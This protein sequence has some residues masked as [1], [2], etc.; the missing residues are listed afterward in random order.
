[1]EISKTI[2]GNL[3]AYVKKAHDEPNKEFEFVL[4]SKQVDKYGFTRIM[5]HLYKN[6]AFNLEDVSSREQLDIRVVSD[7]EDMKNIRMSINDKN[8]IMDY[9]KTGNT[10]VNDLTMMRKYSSSDTRPI[11]LDDYYIRGNLK[12]EENIE[13]VSEKKEYFMKSNN[14]M[15]H[16]R[17]KK[18][19]SFAHN[20]QVCRIDLSIVRSSSKSAKNMVKSGVLYEPENYEVEI[21]Y[22]PNYSN[23]TKSKMDKEDII[24]KQMLQILH[25]LCKLNFGVEYLIPQTKKHTIIQ[26]YVSLVDSSIKQDA[27]ELIKKPGEYCLKYQ[28]VTLMK[29]NLLEPDVDVVSIRDKYCV[30]DK[31]D[32]ERYLLYIS[33]DGKTYLINNV[34]DIFYT[35]L[36]HNNAKKCIIDGELIKK[37]KLNLELNMFAAF[38]IYFIDGKDVRNL[39]LMGEKTTRLSKMQELLNGDMFIEDS[40]SK[41]KSKSQTTINKS[42]STLTIKVKTFE[43]SDDI[44]QSSAKILKRLPSLPYNTDGLIYT[45][46]NL[47]PGALYEN[48]KTMK[49]FGGSW[50]KVFK[51]KPPEDNSID[52]LVKL[53]KPINL[54]IAE[55]L[56]Q[57]CIYVKMYVAFRGS[58]DNSIEVGNIYD[59][60]S[61]VMNNNNRVGGRKQN[62]QLSDNND[63]V[64]RLYDGTYLPIGINDKYPV[65]NS[66]NITNDMI[67]EFSYNPDNIN[68]YKKWIPLRIR[69]DKTDLYLRNNKKIENT[70]NNYLTVVNVW[71][72]ITDPVKKEMLDGSETIDSGVVKNDDNDVY[73][74]RSTPRQRSMLLPML[75]FHNYWIKNV[76][77]LSLFK[78]KNMTLFDIGCGQGGDIPKWIESGFPLV[79][80]IDNNEDNLLNTEHGIYKRYF[81]NINSSPQGNYYGRRIDPE[82]QR[83][84][85]LLMDGGEK[86]T[87]SYVDKIKSLEFKK[88]TKIAMGMEDKREIQNNMLKSFHD[89]M[90]DGFDVVS[91]QFAIHYFFENSDRLDAFCYNV[92][93]MLSKDGYFVGTCLDG[94]IVNNKFKEQ[95]TDVLRGELNGKVLWQMEKSYVD[96]SEESDETN[97]GKEIMVYV[98]TINKRIPEYLVDFELLKR[99]LEIYN[100]RL[101]DFDT[102]TTLYNSIGRSTASFE[103]LYNNM[104]QQYNQGRQHWAIKSAIE[105]MTDVMKEYSFM[106]RWFIFKKYI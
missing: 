60:V 4:S 72:S 73:Y 57:K 90:N 42:S 9:C 98:E 56:I 7:N 75:N 43:T 17:Y 22:T 15:K 51:W 79:V 85:F 3:V 77:S 55:G 41:S 69:K 13:D 102:E 46:I 89:V 39:K 2:F 82:R 26:E 71:R 70:A 101:V 88:L 76:S 12:T 105:N 47:S 103:Y 58:L 48:D 59:K 94:N 44:F 50:S 28:P 29:R 11:A 61:K 1:M 97:L 30:T 78:G 49:P 104:Y 40:Q 52:V 32:G 18:R 19:Y 45:P 23:N 24:L 86:W 10:N 14:L 6:N 96:F 54:E 27:K 62:I 80:G 33:G 38:D 63:F 91:C 74:A 100:I 99:K 34:L 20:S 87:S 67:V 66:E 106:N 37:G 8:A 35:G 93:K 21:E 53:G 92:D 25:K 5:S 16:F 64:H 65:V 83:M 31:A 36:T 95:D 81:E 68:D 84:L